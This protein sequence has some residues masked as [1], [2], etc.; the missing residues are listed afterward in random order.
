MV[1]IYGV[2]ERVGDQNLKEEDTEKKFT[3][4]NNE[5]HVGLTQALFLCNDIMRSQEKNLNQNR[6]SN[7][8]PPDF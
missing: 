6:D 1:G 5:T 8:G 3:D 2:F 4:Y 7:L